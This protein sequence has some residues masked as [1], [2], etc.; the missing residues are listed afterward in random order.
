M[1]PLMQ[2]ICEN[3]PW[4][5]FLHVRAELWPNL[6]DLWRDG[7]STANK[8]AYFLQSLAASNLLMACL[9][10]LLHGP[11]LAR[12]MPGQRVD[13]ILE[14]LDREAL[15]LNSNASSAAAADSVNCAKMD[16]A[17]RIRASAQQFLETVSQQVYIFSSSYSIVYFHEDLIFPFSPYCLLYR[18]FRCTCDPFRHVLPVCPTQTRAPRLRSSILPPY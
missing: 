7:L 18:H 1:L 9:V 15:M 8:P 6:F 10:C 3:H 11:A 14:G 5:L 4:L 16:G 12:G 13:D 17:S 2:C